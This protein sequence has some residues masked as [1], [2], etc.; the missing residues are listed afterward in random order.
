MLAR[1]YTKDEEPLANYCEVC[2]ANQNLGRLTFPGN[3]SFTVCAPC[4]DNPEKIKDWLIRQFTEALSGNA[5][6]EQMGDGRWRAKP[7]GRQSST[8]RS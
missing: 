7:S 2:Q 4:N 5:E 8:Q 1:S 6:F 3:I